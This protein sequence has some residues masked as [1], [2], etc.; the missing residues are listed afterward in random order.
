M[1]VSLK[2]RKHDDGFTLVEL[3][4]VIAILGILAGIAVFSVSGVGDK[5]QSSACKTEKTVLGTAQEAYFA[6]PTGGNGKYASSAATLVPI[7]LNTSP[8][9]YTTTSTTPFTTYSIGLSA[10]GTTAGC[11]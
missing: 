7:F 6:S 9:W 3:L 2:Q 4:V 8:S 11:T 1:L 10:A 5:G